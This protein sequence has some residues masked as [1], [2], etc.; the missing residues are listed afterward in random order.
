MDQNNIP[1]NKKNKFSFFSRKK[2]A[3]PKPELTKEQRRS[4]TIR[5]LWIIFAS[6]IG[7]I[8]LFFLL[9]Y[10]GV[11]GYM[12]DV[13]ELKNPA[14]R[15]ASIIYSADGEE[16]GRFYRNTGNRVYADYDEISQHVV[17][18]LI[19]T[20][21]SRFEEHS[22]IDFRALGRVGFKTLI[23]GDRSSG[24]G[25]TI[26]QQL[27]K[28]LYSPESNSL[29]SRG[30]QKPI[31]WMIAVKLER[32]YTKEEI[33]KMY[34]NQFDFLYNAVGI[35]S[36]AQVYFN[37]HPKDLKIEEAA[38]LVG[39]VKNPSI[40]NPVRNPEKTRER[41]NVVFEQM[42]KAGMLTRAE[43]DSLCRLP[44][45][46]DFHRVD[47]KEGIAPYFRE[48][49]RYMM[50]AKK[51]ERSNYRGWEY[52]KFRADSIEWERNPLFGWIEKNPKPDGSKYDIYTDGLRIYT[53]LDSRMQRYAEEAVAEHLG[54]YLQP[55]FFRE[56]RGSVGAPYSTNRSEISEIRI[57]HL[58]RN[59]MKQTDRW[60][61]MKK[62][63]FSEEDIKAS[64]DKPHEMKLFTYKGAVDTVMTPR[65]SLLYQK[66]ILRTGF[67]A[68]DP[69]NGHVK[70]YVG[71]PDFD[72]FKYDM[73]STGRRQI[74]STVKPFLYSMA[75]EE[76]YTP[77]DMFSNTLPVLYE[78]GRVWRPKSGRA[79][80]G[81]M[82]DL[83]WALT[84]SNNWISAR[85]IST[86][87]PG[88]LV[89]TMQSFGITSKLE[90]VLSLCLGPA[91]V[92]VREMV[93]AYTAFANK[94]MRVNPI[95]VTAI[96]DSNGN[97][98]SQFAPQP[99]EVL[100]EDGYYKIL[101]MLMNVVNS[102]TG[103]RLR[104]APYNLTAEMGGKTGTTNYNAD[105][106]F[107]G[108][109]PNL[110]AGC[111]VGGEERFIHFNNMGYGQGAAMALPIYGL[112]MKKV[113]SDG[114]LPYS[115]SDKFDFPEDI[116]LCDKQFYGSGE[117][118][119]STEQ[120]VV[121]ESI[122]DIFD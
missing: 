1:K 3:A 24:G 21:D 69:K 58:I 81:Q 88:G 95:F 100:S 79:R 14:D 2:T 46:I 77:C 49:I 108:F 68:M 105:G 29:L 57:N 110:V 16:M 4:R 15:F 74:G 121:E 54:G 5:R 55:A 19:A 12:P 91:D 53:T 33:I 32:F 40:Y 6:F 47:I 30:L 71:G 48:E 44:L 59:A 102:G 107:M 101:S 42:H 51:P 89:R 97:I 75:M 50:R 27:A 109:T 45:T 83:K 35:K 26:T 117:G 116:T 93:S 112:F 38:M 86:L 43:T 70:A 34:L 114:S 106:W 87:S 92:S 67:M 31:E 17:N 94:G 7:V 119:S 41:R 60:R 66:H 65:D 8:F 63:G 85:L 37:K 23:M 122:E 28:Q 62:A 115:Q 111:W 80:V 78:Q 9:I 76:G 11:I 99:S 10:N 118:S 73:V 82:V 20:E 90:P 96:V 61:M 103:K 13:E 98:I 84:N 36:A 22:G 18:A 52:D 72:Y 39:M 56:K 64:F 25:S 113:F 120:E 104:G